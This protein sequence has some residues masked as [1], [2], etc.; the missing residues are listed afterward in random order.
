MVPASASDPPAQY[1]AGE[2]I[3]YD[4][5]NHYDAKRRD[6]L[7]RR[8]AVRL[9]VGELREKTKPPSASGEG[10]VHLDPGHVRLMNDGGFGHVAFQFATLRGHQM[11]ARGVLTHD[12]PGPSDFEALRHRFAGLASR[13]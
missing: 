13:D 9:R 10:H 6:H 12:L 4:N 1:D 8:I 7:S 3:D 11:P 5:N 2:H